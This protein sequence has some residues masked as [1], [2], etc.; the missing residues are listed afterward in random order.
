MVQIFSKEPQK[1]RTSLLIESVTHWWAGVT[2]FSLLQ[3]CLGGNQAIWLGA[4]TTR[5]QTHARC[6]LSIS[7][8]NPCRFTT[9]WKVVLFS[10]RTKLAP[11]SY[12]HFTT[13]VHLKVWV[14]KYYEAVCCSSHPYSFL[15]VQYLV[16]DAW[17]SHVHFGFHL[18]LPFDT[19]T[20]SDTILASLLQMLVFTFWLCLGDL[21]EKRCKDFSCHCERPWKGEL[22][23]L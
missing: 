22:Q 14:C 12:Y 6:I 10:R 13:F 4:R 21:L 1:H 11:V 15:H 20:Q 3:A 5:Q 9:N 16:F 2:S 19:S 18:K 7:P 17:H 8:I 23:D